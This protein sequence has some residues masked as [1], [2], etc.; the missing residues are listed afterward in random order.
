MKRNIISSL[1]I[2]IGLVL[3]VSSL[4]IRMYSKNKEAQLIKEFN[5]DIALE[6]S[7][8]DDKNHDKNYGK[9][10]RKIIKYT[11]GDGDKIAIM[12]IPSI[13]LQSIIVEGTNMDDLRYYLGHFKNTAMPGISGNFSIAGHSSTIYNEILNEL[14][15][16]NIKDEI[17]IKTLTGEYDYI[18]TK[19]FVVEPSEVGV[20]DQDENKKSMTIVTCT[21]KGKK[22]LIVKAEMEK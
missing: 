6:N 1:F 11:N 7:K 2:I 16:V 4:G 12:E 22:R 3:M 13:S 19:K 9:Q 21:D 5:N 14:Y 8:N 15:K 17:K 20:L 18:I 10:K